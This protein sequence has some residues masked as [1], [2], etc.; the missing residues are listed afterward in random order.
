M[1]ALSPDPVA[2]A[3][4]ANRTSAEDTVQAPVGG[5]ESST[6]SSDALTANV[7]TVL[8]V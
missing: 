4:P 3:L 2:V 8:V 6:P 1:P 7:L 5:G